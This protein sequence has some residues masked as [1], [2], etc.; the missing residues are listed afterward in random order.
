MWT[1][2]F[3]LCLQMSRQIISGNWSLPL[4]S[5]QTWKV[6]KYNLNFLSSPHSHPLPLTFS[7]IL[8]PDGRCGLELYLF[9][10]FL[11]PSEPW[12][13]PTLRSLDLWWTGC[14]AAPLIAVMALRARSQTIQMLTSPPLMCTATSRTEGGERK[15]RGG[16]GES[17][18]IGLPAPF[19][20]THHEN[21]S[22]RG[23]NYHIHL[24][25]A[26]SV[27][28]LERSPNQRHC[29]WLTALLTTVSVTVPRINK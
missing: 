23:L 6:A 25:R 8:T 11:L 7:K 27:V 21:K 14:T 2:V 5:L 10:F 29:L 9:I 28:V 19:S 22:A 17:K 13:Q 18:V 1:A 26:L 3:Q 24:N 16:M 20:M 15:R 12:H 4:S